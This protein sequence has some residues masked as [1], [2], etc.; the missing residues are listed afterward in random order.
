MTVI[1]IRSD[2]VSVAAGPPPPSDEIIK[3]LQFL[4]R[5]AKT[6]EIQALAYATVDWR[7]KDAHTE[8]PETYTSAFMVEGYRWS[9]LL[10]GLMIVQNRIVVEMGCSVEGIPCNPDP[11]DKPE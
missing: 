10:A 1:P 6:G 11:E 9:R 3:H 4:L 7:A 5:K 2:V 8:D